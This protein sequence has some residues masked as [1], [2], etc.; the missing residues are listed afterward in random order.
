MN[1]RNSTR[2]AIARSG[3][4]VIAIAVLMLGL[5]TCKVPFGL[6]GAVDLEVPTVRITSPQTDT[7]FND[8]FVVSGTVADDLEVKTLI[9]RVLA[10]DGTL[11]GSYPATV[12]DGSFTVTIP[13]ASITAL[14]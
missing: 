14:M 12:S 6:G 8:D 2:F 13:A 1:N 3:L 9:V 7:Y 5:A 4:S 10:S 11:L